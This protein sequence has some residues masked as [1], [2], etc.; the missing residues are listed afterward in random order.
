MREKKLNDKYKKYIESKEWQ[1]KRTE[2][3]KIDNF[4]CQKCGSKRKLHVHHINYENFGNE[5]VYE[6]LITLCSKCHE[7]VEEMKNEQN[8]NYEL[9]NSVPYGYK[10]ICFDSLLTEKWAVFFD[11]CGF[12]WEYKPDGVDV[13]GVFQLYDVYNRGYKKIDLYV[14]VDNTLFKPENCPFYIVK[15]IPIGLDIYD[16]FNKIYKFEGTDYFSFEGV[17]GDC[18]PAGLFVN[19]KGKPV[20]LGGDHELDDVDWIETLRNM[21]IANNGRH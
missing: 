13:D 18:Y 3:L 15:D 10:G 1:A 5:N 2:R 20:L 9:E 4:T 21:L 8:N 16:S 17:D 11:K 7:E 14:V 12:K 19:K 6:D